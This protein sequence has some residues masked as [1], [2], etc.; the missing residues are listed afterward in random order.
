MKECTMGFAFF[1]ILCIGAT[2]TS[3]DKAE[4]IITLLFN[5]DKEQ[6]L[7]ELIQSFSKKKLQGI[8]LLEKIDSGVTSKKGRAALD[9]IYSNIRINLR[10][11]AE[12]DIKDY[13]KKE[14]FQLVDKFSGKTLWKLGIGTGKEKLSLY[15]DAKT[16]INDD[17]KTFGNRLE[18]LEYLVCVDPPD[19]GVGSKAYETLA[20]ITKDEFNELTT[21]FNKY[22]KV[23]H[24]AISVR[25]TD[26]K[27]NLVTFD[28]KEMIIWAM[29]EITSNGLNIGGNHNESKNKSLPPDGTEIQVGIVIPIDRESED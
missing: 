26:K 15:F 18:M 20:G 10:E 17:N 29:P 27:G 13:A 1:L 3:D 8:L 2:V 11:I 21:L 5:S 23:A 7:D 28:L 24:S 22:E 25:W 9:K 19:D 16:F 14:I 12:D 6:V 4:E